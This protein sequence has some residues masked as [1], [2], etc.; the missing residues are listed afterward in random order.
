MIFNFIIGCSEVISKVTTSTFSYH[1]FMTIVIL[2][3]AD[4]RKIHMSMLVNL[5]QEMR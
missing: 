3:D 5:K 2:F 1:Y 4:D